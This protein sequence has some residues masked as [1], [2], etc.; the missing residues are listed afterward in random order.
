MRCSL[1][2][3]IQLETRDLSRYRQYVSCMMCSHARVFLEYVA[4]LWCA[5]R[6]Y[7]VCYNV[8]WCIWWYMMRTKQN[9]I[10]WEYHG[11]YPSPKQLLY[12]FPKRS[13]FVEW[14]VAMVQDLKTCGLVWGWKLDMFNTAISAAP[15]PIAVLPCLHHRRWHRTWLL[16]RHVQCCVDDLGPFGESPTS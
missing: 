10:S 14:N 13:G 15:K 12:I 6:T 11:L 9:E 5:T 2:G 1:A 8:I 7:P 3:Q 16:K 4:R